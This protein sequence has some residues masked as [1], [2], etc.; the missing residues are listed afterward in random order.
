MKTMSL[1][2]G[3]ACAGIALAC[4]N[5]A[6]AD[7]YRSVDENGVVT[8]SDLPSEGAERINV[9]AVPAPPAPPPSAPTAA[10][11][12]EPEVLSG[13]RPREPTEAERAQERARNCTVARER[14]TRYGE[15]L[16]LFRNL[17]DGEREYLTDDEI[18][19][20]RAQAASDVATWCD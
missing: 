2:R 8:Y 4:L 17:P 12:P 19:A 3:F 6:T 16:R 5:T 7:I 11:E 14:M 20:A 18:D 1:V 9:A 10:A 13:E 15:S